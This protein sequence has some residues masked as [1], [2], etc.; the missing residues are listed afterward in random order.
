MSIRRDLDLFDIHKEAENPYEKYFL[1]ENPFPGEGET[2]FDVCSDQDILKKE[3]VSVLM[4]FQ[5]ETKRLRINGRTGAGKTN[6]LK[7]FELLTNT[8]RSLRHIGDLYPIYVQRPGESYFDLHE[9]IVHELTALFLRDLYKGIRSEDNESETNASSNMLSEVMLAVT[10]SRA[11]RFALEEENKKVILVRW[12]KGKKLAASEK[13]QLLPHGPPLPDITSSAMGIRL[14]EEFLGLLRK[15]SLCEGIVL[16]FDE[17]EEIFEV[18]NRARQSR[19]AQDLRHLFDT[20]QESVFFVTATTPEPRDLGQYPAVSRRL[21]KTM[22]L[23][24]ITDSAVATDYVKDYLI[25][26]RE[27]YMAGAR[28][29]ENP[30]D[31]PRLDKEDLAPLTQDDVD[32]VFSSL[33]AETEEGKLDVLP[34]YYLPRLREQTKKI[35]ERHS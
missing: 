17:F 5:K 25:T 26:G 4:N 11:M 18:L 20:L 30:P 35:V 33:K 19:Y 16:L 31:T 2:R 14:L 9:H 29:G 28:A 3:F 34:G 27:K 8:A 13:K 1:R 10:Q 23:Q 32:R 24:P 22:E 7:Y 15:H 21:G 12:L 6:I